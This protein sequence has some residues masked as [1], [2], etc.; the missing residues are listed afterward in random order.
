MMQYAFGGAVVVVQV[1]VEAASRRAVWPSE[2]A[3]SATKVLVLPAR[4]GCTMEM[5][6]EIKSIMHNHNHNSD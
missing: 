6:M 2:V 3:S 1:Q 4:H 5:E